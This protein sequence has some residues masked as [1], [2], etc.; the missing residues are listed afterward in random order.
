ML[1]L[2]QFVLLTSR[3]VPRPYFRT[4]K[5]VK[6]K[7]N[8]RYIEK[9]KP[10][11]EAIFFLISGVFIVTVAIITPYL[12]GYDFIAGVFSGYCIQGGV[13]CILFGS[14]TYDGDLTEKY[15]IEEEEVER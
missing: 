1:I 3:E 11:W 4:L 7:M 2:W 10:D 15:Y 9:S 14:F 6:N 12:S 5:R 13:V 8:R